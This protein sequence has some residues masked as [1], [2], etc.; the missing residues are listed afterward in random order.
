MITG[1]LRGLC[2]QVC[3]SFVVS[4]W[5]SSA[6]TAAMHAAGSSVEPAT[7]A[8]ES[9][10]APSSETDSLYLLD[11]LKVTRA[12]RSR[13][14]PSHTHLRAED[15]AGLHQD[16]PSVLEA[17]SG[18]AVRRTGALG[19][20]SEASVRG[21][22]PQ[23][24]GVYLDGVPLGT[25]SGGGVDIG[26]VPLAMLS[27][28]DIYKGTRPLRY[29]GRNTGGVVDLHSVPGT[30]MI[31]LGGEL[32]S[33]SYGKGSFLLRKSRGRASHHVSV[34]IA[35]ANNDHPFLSD[36]GT[37]YNP[38][39]DT[40][41][42]KHNNDYSSLS[43]LYS[44]SVRLPGTSKLTAYAGYDR[45]EQG[46]FQHDLAVGFRSQ[47][48]RYSGQT[49]RG[50]VRLERPV[51]R[52]V[53][54]DAE[55]QGRYKSTIYDDP[56]GKQELHERFPFVEG[57][58]SGVY[59][60]W[61]WLTV[62]GRVATGYERWDS[63]NRVPSA[64]GFRPFAGRLA[65]RAGAEL[66]MNGG[67]R[68][69]AKLRYV[70]ALEHDRTNSTG[71]V[72]QVYTENKSKETTHF[73]DIEAEAQ[74]RALSFLSLFAG[75]RRAVRTPSFYEKHGRG[76][77]YAGNPRLKPETRLEYD[78]GVEAG[79][80]HLSSSVA[81]FQGRTRNKIKS[82][83]Q[84]QSVYTPLNYADVRH[85]GVEWDSEVRIGSW[86][87]L[88]NSLTFMDNRFG[89]SMEKAIVGNKVPYEP[90]FKD[91]VRLTFH[92]GRLS[93]GHT[94]TYVS[95]YYYDPP[96]RDRNESRPMLSGFV[97]LDDLLGASLTYRL[98]NYTDARNYDFRDHP[99]PGRMH[100]VIFNFSRLFKKED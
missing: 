47:N 33:F 53:R 37:A 100:F 5:A 68:V 84:A 1:L 32:G 24:I 81:F 14:H 48:V 51:G 89:G 13:Y 39:D 35:R 80:E 99:K 6:D 8:G 36:N 59:A 20:Y 67:D 43:A 57:A 50:S 90:S 9:S 29:C 17:I 91:L 15:F 69:M 44:A 19:A 72:A 71:T 85:W 42:S 27:E 45:F 11:D 75:G 73:P 56:D 46:I 66:D 4:T 63:R 92:V 94:F 58:L 22:A 95:S 86:L 10:S 34:G 49:A 78:I 21:G 65:S 52:N 97:R 79:W 7:T 12:A 55:M 25:A 60:P 31:S 61:S 18:V 96:N 76:A 30:D 83:M 88:A 93:V 40:V 16:L 82:I 64:T 70:H 23:E 62:T 77:V 3:V 2:L 87:A 28:I 26:K 98:E 38:D 54:I 74:W 41:I